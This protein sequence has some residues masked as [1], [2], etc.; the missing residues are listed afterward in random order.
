MEISVGRILPRI[1][2]LYFLLILN[3]SLWTSVTSDSS[4]RK[5]CKL[6]C[7]WIEGAWVLYNPGNCKTHILLKISL[8]TVCLHVL[9]QQIHV[10]YLSQFTNRRIKTIMYIPYWVLFICKH[11][12]FLE[13]LEKKMLSKLWKWVLSNCTAFQ[14]LSK[15]NR[16]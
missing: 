11:W 5:N 3:L 16:T 7:K 14:G 2:L 9:L 10:P 15:L 13:G 4:N 1:F 8:A 6:P 12:M